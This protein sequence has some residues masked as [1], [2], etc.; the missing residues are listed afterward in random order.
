MFGGHDE[1]TAPHVQLPVDRNSVVF[2][3]TIRSAHVLE[4]L[5]GRSPADNVAPI[6]SSLYATT[7]KF[8]RIPPEGQLLQRFAVAGALHGAER[9]AAHGSS[10]TPQPAVRACPRSSG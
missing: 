2:V 8:R 10:S 6:R 4:A 9:A 7:G 3:P 1:Q 5:D